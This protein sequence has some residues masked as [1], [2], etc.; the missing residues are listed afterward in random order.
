MERHRAAE[1]SATGS[2]LACATPQHRSRHWR[3]AIGVRT[4]TAKLRS[5]FHARPPRACLDRALVRAGALSR[6]T[7]DGVDALPRRLSAARRAFAH[8]QTR[9]LRDFGAP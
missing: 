8:A 5:G 7:S 9:S 1:R 6:R 2:E 3:A 4:R